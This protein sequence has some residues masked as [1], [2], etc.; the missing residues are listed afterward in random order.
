[1]SESLSAQS[2][3]KKSTEFCSNA[4]GLFANQPMTSVQGLPEPPVIQQAMVAWS[5]YK[6]GSGKRK[7]LQGGSSLTCSCTRRV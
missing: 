5:Q 7:C 6:E 2:R 1:M 3:L 4:C